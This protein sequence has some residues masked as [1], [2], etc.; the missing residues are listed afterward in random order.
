MNVYRYILTDLVS[1]S[2]ELPKF[3]F[4]GGLKEGLVFLTAMEESLGI[5]LFSAEL[6]L[7]AFLSFLDRKIG[8]RKKDI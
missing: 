2:L 7:A 5:F 8:A 3:L 1:Q 4:E 6:S